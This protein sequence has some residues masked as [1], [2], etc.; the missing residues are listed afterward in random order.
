MGLPT[1]KVIKMLIGQEGKFSQ[2]GGKKLFSQAQPL[3][4]TLTIAR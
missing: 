2:N 3:G 4:Y 1:A